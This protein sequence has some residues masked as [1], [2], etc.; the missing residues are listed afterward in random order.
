MVTAG[1]LWVNLEKRA[2]MKL[3]KL[4]LSRYKEKIGIQGIGATICI[5][6]GSTPGV[7]SYYST[8][9]TDQGLGRRVSWVYS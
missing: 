8:L 7:G 6:D 2:N 9:D 4:A 1:L 3:V 5:R